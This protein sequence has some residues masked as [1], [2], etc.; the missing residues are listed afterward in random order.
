LYAAQLDAAFNNSTT[1]GLGEKAASNIQWEPVEF[2]EFNDV[3]R[4]AKNM[5]GSLNRLDLMRRHLFLLLFCV[6]DSKADKKS[7]CQLF[8]NAGLGVMDVNLTPH[9]YD[10]HLT[11]NNLAHMLF[12]RFVQQRAVANPSI[13]T[14]FNQPPTGSVLP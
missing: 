12:L 3:V 9:G 14:I 8:G 4:F 1:T 13:L 5:E 6:L 11:V 7:S 10:S 2:C